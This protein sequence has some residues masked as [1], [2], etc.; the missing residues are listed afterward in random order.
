MINHYQTKENRKLLD[1]IGWPEWEDD[2][3]RHELIWVSWHNG[4]PDP[5]LVPPLVEPETVSG[6]WKITPGELPDDYVA[7]CILQAH[8]REYIESHDGQM[9]P[10]CVRV[11]DCDAGKRVDCDY[12]EMILEKARRILTAGKES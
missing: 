6:Y 3:R 7:L 5:A 11:Y 4:Y 2:D 12:D 1:E 8:L 10:S 9:P